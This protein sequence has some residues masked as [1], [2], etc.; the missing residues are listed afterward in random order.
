MIFSGPELLHRILGDASQWVAPRWGT[1]DERS[2]APLAITTATTATTATATTIAT[3]A[4][5]TTSAITTVTAAAL[6]STTTAL[7]AAMSTMSLKRKIK[8]TMQ[9]NSFS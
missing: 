1:H 5:T 6:P 2:A 7:P 8:T 3:T 9:Q 4:T